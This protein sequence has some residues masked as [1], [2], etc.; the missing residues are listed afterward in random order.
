MQEVDPLAIYRQTVL[1]K[2]KSVF[3]GVSDTGTASVQGHIFQKHE[4]LINRDLPFS[5]LLLGP[6]MF[7]PE[8]EY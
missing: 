2:S 5:S 1:S 4:D 3:I 6:K 8:K 7:D